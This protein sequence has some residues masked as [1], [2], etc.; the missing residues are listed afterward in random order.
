MYPVGA[1]NPEVVA[2]FIFPEFVV[3]V[4]WTV[5]PA[6][7]PLIDKVPAEFTSAKLVVA[8]NELGKEIAG[9]ANAVSD[10]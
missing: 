4:A 6:S 8:T 7:Y 5:A 2:I 3:T 9:A 1:V 10:K